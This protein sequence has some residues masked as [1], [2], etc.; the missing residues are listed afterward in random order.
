MNNI[1][2]FDAPHIER[3]S[4]EVH[5]VPIS[6]ALEPVAF[7][8]SQGSCQVL[9]RHP[10]GPISGF[11]LQRSTVYRLTEADLKNIG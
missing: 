3:T 4:G 1:E 8:D 11:I 6:Y 10:L 2:H 9:W 7:H 5:V